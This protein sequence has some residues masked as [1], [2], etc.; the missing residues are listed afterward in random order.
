MTVDMTGGAPE[1]RVG[2]EIELGGLDVDACARV[3]AGVFGGEVAEEGRFERSVATDLGEFRVELDAGWLKALGRH[4]QP[5]GAMEEAVGRALETVATE[6]VPCEIVAPPIPRRDLGALDR[7]VSALGDAGGRGTYE[8]LR[9]GFG[10]HFNPEVDPE[11]VHAVRRTMQAFAALHG[12]LSREYHVDPSRRL[13][14]FIDP[15][16]RAYRDRLME[17]GYRPRSMSALMDDYLELTP[18]RNRALDLL[19]LFAHVD[20]A[21]VRDRVG[22]EKVSPRPT[23]HYRMCNSRV[24]HPDWRLTQ[25]WTSWLRVEALAADP[26]RLAR[27]L[28]VAPRAP[29]PWD[30]LLT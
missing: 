15:W 12:R 24:G 14:T 20:E 2:V 13:T 7:L 27:E 30:G 21:R 1:A 3:V 16:P 17:P 23:F 10:V 5:P 22:D 26:A 9:F 28:S 4:S 6:V 29:L 19:P 8:A 18:T 11:D 25:E